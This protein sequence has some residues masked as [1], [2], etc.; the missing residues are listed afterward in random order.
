MNYEQIGLLINDIEF[1]PQDIA[2]QH[3][4]FAVPPNVKV[5]AVFVETEEA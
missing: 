3:M 2:D 5:Q 1:V 4:P